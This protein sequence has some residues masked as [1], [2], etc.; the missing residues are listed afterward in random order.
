MISWTRGSTRTPIF[1]GMQRTFLVWMY[2]STVFECSLNPLHTLSKVHRK[3]R[4]IFAGI[5]LMQTQR[6]SLTRFDIQYIIFLFWCVCWTLCQNQAYPLQKTAYRRAN[7][8][9]GA[10]G[11]HDDVAPKFVT[12]TSLSIK[13]RMDQ[14]WPKLVV[15]K[16]FLDLEDWISQS[17]LKQTCKDVQRDW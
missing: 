1:W 16:T 15:R 14:A 11:V 5:V 8:G 6:E 2:E 9:S 10:P 7:G 12:S 17:W 3:C 4:R 13:E